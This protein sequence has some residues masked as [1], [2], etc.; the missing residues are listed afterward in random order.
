MP[1]CNGNDCRVF[2]ASIAK[3]EIWYDY[4]S[5]EDNVHVGAAHRLNLGVILL[6]VRHEFRK[7]KSSEHE[8]LT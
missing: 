7:K 6:N 5:A 4:M 1:Q 8:F 3:S 2:A